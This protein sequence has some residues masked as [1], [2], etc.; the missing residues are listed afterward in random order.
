MLGMKARGS[1][2]SDLTPRGRLTEATLHDVVGYQL[3]QAAI[4]T[5]AV[6]DDQVL[7]T[8]GLRRAEFTVLALIAENPGGTPARLASALAV[9]AGNITLWVD[10]LVERGWV[11]REASTRDRRTQHL[12]AT[13]DG[14]RL[15]TEAMA[16]IV[17]AEAA[18]LKS[19]SAAERAMLVELLHKLAASR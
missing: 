14:A 9:T 18:Q 11:R 7:K 4:V 12:H 19:L 10:R 15:V 8:L 2:T 16:R 13:A 5:N 17:A 6:F 1:A 3:A